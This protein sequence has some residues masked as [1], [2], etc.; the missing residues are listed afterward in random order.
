MCFNMPQFTY[1]HK[2]KMSFKKKS[3]L[4]NYIVSVN[5]GVHLGII[6]EFEFSQVASIHVCLSNK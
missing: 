2:N 6:L 4:H 3:T 1:R 5:V